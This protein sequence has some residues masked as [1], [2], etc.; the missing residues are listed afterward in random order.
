MRGTLA[1]CCARP[2][3]GHDAAAPPSSDMNSRRLLPSPEHAKFGFQLG[4]LEQE[5]ATSEMGRN[6]QFAPQQS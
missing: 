6:G 4:Q 1:A 2:A 3:S 5:I